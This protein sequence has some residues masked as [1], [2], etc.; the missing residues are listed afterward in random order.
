MYC[1]DFSVEVLGLFRVEGDPAIHK[2]KAV[3]Y[4][5]FEFYFEDFAGGT[6]TEGVFRPAQKGTFCLFKPGQPQRLVPYYQCYVMNIDTKD[7][8]LRAILDKL[9]TQAPLWNTAEVIRLLQQMLAIRD[10]REPESRLLLHS[11]A[12]RILALVLE[13]SRRPGSTD[14]NVLRHQEQLLA[15]DRYIRTHPEQKLSLKELAQ[16]CNLDPTYFHKLFTAAFG[17]TPAQRVLEHRIDAV[18]TGLLQTETSM[19]EL[20]ERCG[21]SSASYLGYC[22]KQATGMTPS[23]YRRRTIQIE[24]D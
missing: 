6:V 3:Y 15:L 11:Y 12:G 14:A 5:E 4:Y 21:F 22:F 1:P 20:A 16:Q 13:A 2:E 8:W 18:K 23:E 9:P 10:K 7:T 24:K 19:E 17:K